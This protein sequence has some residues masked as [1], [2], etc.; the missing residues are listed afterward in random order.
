MASEIPAAIADPVDSPVIVNAE[1]EQS[2][3]AAAAKGA[4]RVA[5]IAVMIW[6][7]FAAGL[8]AFI[9]FARVPLEA[10]W[11]QGR[12]MRVLDIWSLFVTELTAVAG[13]LV[14]P[15]LITGIVMVVL[16]GS[17]LCLWLALNATSDPVPDQPD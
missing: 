1:R 10:G 2:S 17:L 14:T 5:A 8:V 9:A 3:P 13:P 12:S 4:R 6:L 7:V 11:R 15:A 16:A